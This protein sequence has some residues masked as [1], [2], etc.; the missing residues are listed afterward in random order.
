MRTLLRVVLLVLTLPVLAR[1]IVL[2]R[3]AT[4]AVPDSTYTGFGGIVAI[5]GDYAIASGSRYI[6]APDGNPDNDD[7]RIAFW[8]LQRSGTQWNVVRQLTEYRQIPFVDYDSAAAMQNGVAAVQLGGRVEFYELRAGGWTFVNSVPQEQAGRYLRAD[9]GRFIGGEGGCTRDGRVFARDST[10]T[11][12]TQALLR[13]EPRSDGCDDEFV[14]H[15]VDIAGNWAVV[16]QP[17]PED[18][19]PKALIFRDYGGTQGWY[20]LPYG[21]ARPPANASYFGLDVAFHGMN[22]IVS[23]GPESGSYVYRE[24]PARGFQLVDRIQTVDGFMGGNR[25]VDYARHGDLLLGL[26]HSADR[27]AGVIHVFRRDANNAYEHV[28]ILAGRN[29]ESLGRPAI[30]GRRVLVSTSGGLVNYFELPAS[31]AAPALLQDTFESGSSAGWTTSAGSAFAT[32]ASAG[33][34]VFRQTNVANEARAVLNASDF[35]S[36]AVEADL[37]INAFG[38]AGSGAGLATRYQGPTNWFD[39]VVRNTGRVE[40]RRMASGTLRVLASTSFTPVV[41]RT[42]RLR[43]ESVGTLHRVSID[44]RL[45]LDYDIGGATHGN[46]VLYTDRANAE[47]DNVVVSPSLTATIYATDFNNQDATAW[48]RTGLGFWNFWTGESTVWNQSSVAGDARASVGVPT[49]DQIVRVRARLDTFATPTGTQERWFGVMAR[50][51]DDRNYY[52]LTLRSSNTVSLRK[53]VDGA[54]TVLDTAALTVTPAT[55]YSLRLDAV[56]G[57]LRAYVNGRLLLETTDASHPR[58]TAGPVMFKAA[59]DYDDFSSLQP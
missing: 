57:E 9:G 52:Y 36:Q 33:S 56:G 1:P 32:V 54:V 37:R 16:H 31:F 34:R 50:Y 25:I 13:G 14:G 27:D 18:G 15:T 38:A 55:W 29:G 21:D 2:E 22:V 20:L 43:L 24:I 30:S 41:G 51:V 7:D 28:A 19:F 49:D 12:V 59:V 40:L 45:L 4:I 5:D 47:F 8:L 23:G 53:L 10:G 39:V 44:G 26:A 11:W 17:N 58:G 6:P 46:A 48:T 3:T 35:K 42:Y